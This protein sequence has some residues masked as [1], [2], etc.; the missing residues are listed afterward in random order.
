G[1]SHHHHHHSSG[2]V[3]RGSHMMPNKVRKIG[4]LVRYLNTNPVGGLLEYA[5][6]HGFA[7]E[8]KLVD[9]SGPPHEPK[10]VYQAKVGG[11]WFPAVCAHS[12]KQGKQEAADAA[13]RVLIGENE[14]A[15]R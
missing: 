14:K 7:A 3:P 10:F 9:Q 13:L 4:E 1:S 15:E 5:R 11:R 12:K 2:L 8:F 6:S